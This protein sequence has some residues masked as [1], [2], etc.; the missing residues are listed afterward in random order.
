MQN[1]D[2]DSRCRKPARKTV[3]PFHEKSISTGVRETADYLN[4]SLSVFTVEDVGPVPGPNLSGKMREELNQLMVSSDVL[5]LMNKLRMNKSLDLNGIY[6][7]VFKELIQEGA[8]GLLTLYKAATDKMNSQLRT[9]H[10]RKQQS[11]REITLSQCSDALNPI[12]H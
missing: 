6:P 3:E 12:R 11:I 9:L 1:A 2:A 5:G 10:Q 4:K 8:Q 7:R